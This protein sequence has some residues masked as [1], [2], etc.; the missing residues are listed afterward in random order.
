MAEYKLPKKTLYLWKVRLA[1]VF[2]V[3]LGVF[4]YFCHNYQWYLVATLSIICIFQLL[5][6]WYIPTLF[7]KYS[8]KYMNG[9]IVIETGVIIKTTHIMP[10]SKMIYTQSI[11]SPLAKMMGL[12]A[13]TLKAARSRLLIP[14]L[15]AGEAELFANALAEG[16]L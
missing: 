6:F 11:T 16:E 4:S 3:I 14:E 7:K 5:F 15:N 9:A 13:I 1:L 8:I 10:F 12:K 2:A